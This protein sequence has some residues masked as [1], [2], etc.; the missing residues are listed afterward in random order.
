[1]KPEVIRVKAICVFRTDD[2]ILVFEAF[3]SA[4]GRR[5]YRP[6][7]GAVEP[8]ET[9][10]EAIEREIREE[11]GLDISRVRLLGTLEHLFSYE[12][13]PG[14]EIVFVYDA[15]FNNESVYES[16]EVIV[17]QDD[18]DTI[19]AS[20]RSIHSFDNYH[21]LAPESLASLLKS[22]GNTMTEDDPLSPDS[23]SSADGHP[24][25]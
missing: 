12:G 14:H 7:G 10:H 3:D 9:S 13:K 18:G 19:L 6:L 16:N 8:G 23:N 22:S 1:M 4:A 17:H 20:W 11:V 25:C 24:P 2:R 21:R 15:C 5:F